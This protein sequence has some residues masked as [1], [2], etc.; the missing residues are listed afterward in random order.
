VTATGPPP[1][2]TNGDRSTREFASLRERAR[3]DGIAIEVESVADGT[4]LA[5]RVPL[6]AA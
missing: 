2:S 6:R 4:R 5:W 3:E 1:P